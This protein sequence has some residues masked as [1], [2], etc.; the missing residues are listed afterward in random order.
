MENS[1]FKAQ[2][3]DHQIINGVVFYTVS[4]LDPQTI[5]TYFLSSR[6]SSLLTLHES[7]SRKYKEGLILPRFPPKKWFG[8]LKSAFIE[9]RKKLLE[10]YFNAFLQNVSL[11]KDPLTLQYF[12]MTE[13]EKF[14]RKNSSVM[15]NTEP[16]R[17]SITRKYNVKMFFD[18]YDAHANKSDKSQKNSFSS[19]G[20]CPNKALDDMKKFK[21]GELHLQA[22][23]LDYNLVYKY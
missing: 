9:Q 23:L 13:N 15:K 11:V 20:F 22:F 16:L 14:F 3:L 5:K 10:G 21:N 2:F 7:L 12:E 4:M 18:D 6:Y 1:N 19:I 8:N 17:I